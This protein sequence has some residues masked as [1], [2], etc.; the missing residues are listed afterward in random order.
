MFWKLFKP[1]SILSLIMAFI[2]TLLM[3]TGCG[4]M[5]INL[6]DTI[7]LMEEVND[8]NADADAAASCILDADTGTHKVDDEYK[9][10]IELTLDRECISK[11]ALGKLPDTDADTDADTD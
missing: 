4:E 10:T 8:D 11:V 7:T 2:F 5:G 3:L 1:A 6:T 9:D